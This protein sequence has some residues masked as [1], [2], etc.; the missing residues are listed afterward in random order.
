[1]ELFIISG[2]YVLSAA[3]PIIGLIRLHKRVKDE[4]VRANKAN[5]GNN[6]QASYAGA[7]HLINELLKSTIDRPKAVRTDFFLV[8][9]GPILGA[10]ASVW[11]IW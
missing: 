7:D 3:L 9:G 1:M 10:I 6:E 8:G 11:A 5:Y 2:L 4:A